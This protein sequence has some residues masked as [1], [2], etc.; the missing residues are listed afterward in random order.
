MS[1]RTFFAVALTLASLAAPVLASPPGVGPNGGIR[2]DTGTVHVEL[3]SDGTPTITVYISDSSYSPL[4]AA[5][6]SGNA[7]LLVDGKPQ[8]FP[9]EATDAGTLS[10]TAAVPVMQDVKGALQLTAPDGSS[11]QAKY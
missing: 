9:L 7:I 8:R 6:W 4:D 2:V 5:G 10:G 3:V 1:V 11:T